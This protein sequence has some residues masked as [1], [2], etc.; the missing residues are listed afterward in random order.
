L[1]AKLRF[2]A[3]PEEVR[4][5]RQRSCQGKCVPKFNLGTRKR[6]E[7]KREKGKR[8]KGGGSGDEEMGE[9]KRAKGKGGRGFLKILRN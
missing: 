7:G 9:G 1:G 4:V 2:A 3:V 8:Q 6:G 5:R